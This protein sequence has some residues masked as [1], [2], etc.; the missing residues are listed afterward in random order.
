LIQQSILFEGNPDT[1]NI[2]ERFL[3]KHEISTPA[4]QAP[5]IT[6][7]ANPPVE[8]EQEPE[9]EEPEEQ[10]QANPSQPPQTTTSE[11][12]ALPTAPMETSGPTSTTTPTTMPI[13]MGAEQGQDLP[14]A[15]SVNGIAQPGS[16][17]QNQDTEMS[18]AT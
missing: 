9:P 14:P 12:H 13:A 5:S 18:N 8:Q 3:Y 6:P 16:E 1:T 4:V 15:S 7:A 11:G 10:Q 2:R 17:E